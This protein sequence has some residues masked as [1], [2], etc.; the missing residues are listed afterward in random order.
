MRDGRVC[1]ITGASSGFGRG[2]MT[3][4]LVAELVLGGAVSADLSSV[5]P[6]D[7]VRPLS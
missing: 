1:F 2:P 6:T 7:R 3:G 5:L 4:Q